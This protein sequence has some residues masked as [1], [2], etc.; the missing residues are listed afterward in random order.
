MRILSIPFSPSTARLFVFLFGFLISFTFLFQVSYAEVF[1][2]P[3]EYLGYF[4][5]NGIYTVI[6][7][8]KNNFEY[9]IIPTIDVSIKDNSEILSKTIKHVPLSSDSELPFKIK[10]P[11]VSSDNPVLLPPNVTF[12]I[13]NK[14]PIFLEVIY[15]ETLVQYEDGHLTGRIQNT[16]NTT[17]F[18][19][20]IY[21]VIHGY[22]QVLDIVQNMER[23]NKIDPGEIVNFS[24][25]PDPSV[26]DDIFYYSCFAP[27]D[28]TV[29]PVTTIKN[30]EEFDFRYDSGAWYSAAKFNE[31][32]TV[33]S[34][35]GYNSYPLETYANFE[36]APISGNE[37]FDVTLNDEPIEFIQ[38]LD[39]MGYWH[40]AFN[41]DPRSQGILKIS[42][43][44]IG[45]PSQP[46]KIPNWIKLNAN[47]WATDQ[48]S[49]DE[50][51]E[52]IDFLIQKQLVSAP[53][54]YTSDVSKQKIP[55]WLKFSANWWATDQ[56]SDDEFLKIIETLIQRQIIVL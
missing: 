41:V 27:V 43:F 37:K 1:V 28:T 51:L 6:G 21:A 9:A 3:E 54:E 19:P 42:G 5:S 32:G 14:D 35:R 18:N 52:G 40:V 17:I 26:T 45:I 38:S 53:M 24:M 30:G 29:V 31:E 22:E 47:W 20:K 48:I 56:I 25:Y 49:D 2:P 10:F 23:I 33:L 16:G 46:S 7:N 13:T 12:E 44:E 50:F 34:I 15:D 36:F 39:E 11:E 55:Q 4:D 8:V